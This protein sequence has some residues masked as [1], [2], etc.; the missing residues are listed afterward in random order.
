M[1]ADAYIAAVAFY[2]A[3]V[4]LLA[5]LLAAVL[6]RAALDLLGLRLAEPGTGMAQEPSPRATV[7]LL[8]QAF[9]AGLR[10]FF[11]MTTGWALWNSLLFL[12]GLAGLLRADMVAGLTALLVGLGL[13][14]AWRVRGSVASAS[15]S[16]GFHMKWTRL[17]ALELWGF[18][19]L[20]VGLTWWCIRPPGMWDDTSYHLPYA[21]HYLEAAGITINP[22]LRFPLFPHHP[23]LMFAVGLMG[24]SEVY[25]QVLAGAVPMSL[26]AL[27]LF[28]LARRAG[29]S[30]PAGALALAVLAP[31][32]PLSEAMGYA[33]VDH[34]LM[35]WVWAA[36]ACL[37]MA[38]EQARAR[39]PWP[40][41]ILCAFFAGTAASTKTFGGLCAFLIGLA[42][43][44]MPGLG[45]RSAWRYA[46]VVLLVGGGWYLR[47][48][49]I[50]GDPFHPLGGNLFGHYL[51]NAQ[52]LAAQHQ[53]KATLGVSRSLL[54]LPQSLQA[55]GLTALAFALL[56]PCRACLRQQPAV[57]GILGVL[58][59]FTLIWHTSTQVARY[60]GP[61]LPA[62]AFMVG[63]LATAGSEVRNPRWSRV[64]VAA[65]PGVARVLALAGAAVAVVAAAVQWPEMDQRLRAWDVAVQARPGAALFREAAARIPTHGRVLVQLGYENAV[66][67]FPARVVGDWFGPG[68]Y[69]AMLRC[70]EV[71]RPL[72][73]G[74]LVALL[75]QH[76]ARMAAINTA[77]FPAAAEDYAGRFSVVSRS[78]DGF[79]LVLKD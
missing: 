59:A 64:S 37:W 40:W 48:F 47:S 65:S 77:R 61:V 4:T 27:G 74:E 24:G 79:L 22:D 3:G 78:A 18:A 67:F 53:E 11:W 50:S 16:G 68:R 38:A 25:A 31:F 71:C 46:L 62:A 45:W 12:L 26:T 6:G 30:W 43:L 32:K 7:A 57:W 49:V 13:T 33:Y 52:D 76:K 8:P 19:C 72:P 23:Q 1:T 29:R 10:W 35:L 36:L 41:V 15:A 28:S 55:A 42:V 58:V 70:A 39:A 2:H 51:W 75:Q 5:C 44:F 73:E 9:P 14:Y 21:R 60:I 20:L 34:L 69:A 63:L 56:A 54:A 66:Y 17:D